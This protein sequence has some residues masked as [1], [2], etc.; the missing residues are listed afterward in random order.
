MLFM[1]TPNGFIIFSSALAN[2]FK[3]SVFISSMVN[4]NSYNPHNQK[5]FG[6]SNI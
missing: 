2:I 5:L 6:L 3:F 4:V 1:L